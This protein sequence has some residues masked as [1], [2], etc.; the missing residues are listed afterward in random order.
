MTERP[1][2]STEQKD[3]L[4]KDEPGVKRI[5]TLNLEF[6]II[7]GKSIRDIDSETRVYFG[8]TEIEI[9]EQNMSIKDG[10]IVKT[11]IDFLED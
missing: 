4:Y 9:E 11:S 2:Y 5:G 6:P 1:I 7:P 3:V 8:H 10:E